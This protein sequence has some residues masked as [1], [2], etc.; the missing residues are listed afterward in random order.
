MEDHH[1]IF[2]QKIEKRFIVLRTTLHNMEVWLDL[3]RTGNDR[4]P[5]AKKVGRKQNKNAQF[6]ILYPTF[7][8]LYIYLQN[9]YLYSEISMRGQTFL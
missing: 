5:Y 9:M 7:K 6:V 4:G 2:H 1:L 8:N 3:A